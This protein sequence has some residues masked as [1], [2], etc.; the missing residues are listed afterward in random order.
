MLYICCRHQL[1][2]PGKY[3]QLQAFY[4]D[5]TTAALL[6]LQKQSK[7]NTPTT[8]SRDL[9]PELKVFMS[10]HTCI[11]ASLYLY[12]GAAKLI[13]RIAQVVPHPV[14]TSEIFLEFII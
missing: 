3:T 11:L 7:S 5:K 4:E 9:L 6:A 2:T 13:V 14:R 10:K 1:E 12:A 8:P